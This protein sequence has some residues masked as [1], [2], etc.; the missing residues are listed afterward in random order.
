MEIRAGMSGDILYS[1]YYK[2][3][4]AAGSSYPAV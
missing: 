1:A 4:V 2:G 3:M